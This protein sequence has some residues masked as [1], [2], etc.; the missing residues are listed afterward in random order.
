M[1]RNKAT[2]TP[3][4]RRG[5]P[6]EGDETKSAHLS[7]KISRETRSE[8][9]AAAERTGRSLNKEAEIALGRGLG[10]QESFR[11]GLGTAFGHQGAAVIELMSYLMHEPRDW[12]NRADTFTEVRQRIDLI[13]NAFGPSP[14]ADQQE[15]A[16]V[17]D[18]QVRQLLK[19]A[20]T[21]DPD[22][23][24]WRT[25]QALRD[26]LGPVPV[27]RLERWLRASAP[28]ERA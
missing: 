14:P 21:K 12:L 11:D 5:R 9:E 19:S 28:K 7:L 22:S 8:L 23:A 26:R 25:S 17:E 6:P 15:T 10:G 2:A 27:E 4:R 1:A 13:L 18:V 16:A 20:F 24:W 3:P